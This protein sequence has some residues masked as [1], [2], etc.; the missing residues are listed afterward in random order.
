MDDPHE[1]LQDMQAA[2][3]DQHDTADGYVRWSSVLLGGQLLMLVVVAAFWLLT[4][5]SLLGLSTAGL[6][7]VAVINVAIRW[8]IGRLRRS[9]R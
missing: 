5:N 9:M 7:I 4:S 6:G 3:R 2:I 1:D 8:H